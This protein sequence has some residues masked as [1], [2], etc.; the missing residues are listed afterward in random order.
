VFVLNELREV[1]CI[2]ITIDNGLQALL[3]RGV[4][5]PSKA[6]GPLFETV[7]EMFS[8]Q[9]NKNAG[10]VGIGLDPNNDLAKWRL[11]NQLIIHRHRPP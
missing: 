2:A 3:V 9:L 6:D 4:L 8:P 11:S 7:I 10:I 5:H 1:I